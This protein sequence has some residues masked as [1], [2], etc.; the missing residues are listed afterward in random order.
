MIDFP[1]NQT[2]LDDLFLLKISEINRY[3]LLQETALIKKFI[4]LKE[5]R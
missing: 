1:D 4:N 5:L 3:E 2:F